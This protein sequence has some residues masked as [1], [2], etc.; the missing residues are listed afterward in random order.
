VNAA[1]SSVVTGCGQ[2]HCGCATAQP[3]VARIN[4][5]ALHD[6]GHRPEPE[7]LRERAY[8][9]L[10]RQHAVRCGL[11]PPFEG[12]MAPVPDVAT[13]EVL[14]HMVEQAISP[15]L[16]TETEC[17][18]YYE[19]HRRDFVHGQAVHL[20]HILFAVTPGVNVH[21]L[22]QRAESALL[23]LLRKETP[24]DRFAQLAAELSNCPTGVQGGDL[25]W[26]TPQDC[27]AELANEL[28]ELKD[29][30]W[31]AGPHPRLIHTRFGFHIVEVLQRRT[32]KL[33]PL[34][35]VKDRIAR[36][37]TLQSRARATHQ[38]MQVLAGQAD[39]EGLDL[40]GT[41]TPLVQ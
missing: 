1:S 30:Q 11:L 20:R 38:Y 29:T 19:S 23:E 35:E 9:E 33:A 24:V 36:D 37:L 14:T 22:T 13:M 8:T 12:P 2:A 39:L 6:A 5:V 7:E 15:P 41:G 18:R 26:V 16:P 34:A 25:G 21:A 28:F 4:G 10:L 32:G 27:A 31:P 17:Q 3:G 40:G